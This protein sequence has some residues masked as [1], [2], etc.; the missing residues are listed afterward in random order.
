ML[1]SFKSVCRNEKY[2]RE[3]DP[4]AWQAMSRRNVRQISAARKLVPLWRVFETGLA[5]VCC[6]SFSLTLPHVGVVTAILHCCSS[7]MDTFPQES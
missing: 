2:D 7:F 4:T 1:K 3:V 5:Q 6:L